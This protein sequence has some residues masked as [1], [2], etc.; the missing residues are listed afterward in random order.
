MVP[1]LTLAGMAV[2]ATVF[3]SVLRWQE[4][5]RTYRVDDLKACMIKCMGFAAERFYHNG[6]L[7]IELAEESCVQEKGAQILFT[8][9]LH[10]GEIYLRGNEKD[11]YDFFGNSVAGDEGL[12]LDQA[13]RFRKSWIGHIPE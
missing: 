3:I 11:A 4:A 9:D 5:A 13:G 1:F 12:V 6:Q 8:L 10:G 7:E 2:F